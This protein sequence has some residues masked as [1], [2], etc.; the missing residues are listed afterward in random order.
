[1][2][3]RPEQRCPS[4]IRFANGDVFKGEFRHG[5][6]CGKGVQKLVRSHLPSVRP[7]GQALGSRGMDAIFVGDWSH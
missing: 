3:C 7:R 6:P 4:L 5:Q 2:L 1:M